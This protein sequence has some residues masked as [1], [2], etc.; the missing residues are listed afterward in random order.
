[1]DF[2]LNN[3]NI[4]ISFQFTEIYCYMFRIQGIK[5]KLGFGQYKSIDVLIIER[6]LD[7]RK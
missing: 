6:F 7:G 2:F 5:S 4:F 1:M 3:I